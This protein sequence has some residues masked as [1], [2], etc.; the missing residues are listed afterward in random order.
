MGYD[1]IEVFKEANGWKEVLDDG[2][3]TETTTSF[4]ELL[5]EGWELILKESRCVKRTPEKPEGEES[6]PVRTPFVPGVRRALSEVTIYVLR[7]ETQTD[8]QLQEH[9]SEGDGL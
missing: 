7:R 9:A 4:R 5:S 6:P 3:V 8:F 1:V 2:T